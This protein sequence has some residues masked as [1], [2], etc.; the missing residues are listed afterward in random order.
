[1]NNS[2]EES[3]GQGSISEDGNQQ[4]IKAVNQELEATGTATIHAGTYQ[5]NIRGFG[6]ASIRGWIS[7]LTEYQAMK[8]FDPVNGMGLSI[9]RVRVSPNSADFAAEK[10]TIDR[11]K[12]YGASVIA[13]AWTAPADMKTNNNIVGGKL[14]PES[15]A[16]YAT[17]LRN[18]TNTVGGVMAVSPWNEPDWQVNYESMN[19]TAQE[20]GNFIANHGHNCG[21]PVM[22]PE[23]LGMNQS[24]TTTVNNI[25]GARLTYICGHI[26]GS[27]PYVL[28][29]GK[30][31]W[32]TEHITDTNDA[33]I[34]SGAMNTAR[35]IHN[36]MNAGWNMWVWW[37]IRRSY[38]LI[39]EDNNLT[40][41][42][43]VATHFSKFIRPGY[44]KIECTANP[45]S[46]VY[47]TAYRR[48][49]SI[50][51]VAINENTSVTYQPFTMNGVSVTGFDR[52]RTTSSSN[53]QQDSF[54]VSDGS[55]GINLPAQSI[56]TLVSR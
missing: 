9:L 22:A 20:I 13:T 38:G 33:N 6:G 53:L 52:W 7:D 17:H 45:T 41:R 36:V 26:Y 47:T 40:K 3:G 32:M 12:S 34:W 48:G 51:I 44:N 19:D 54:S 43:Y 56:T 2:T 55:F 27:S 14:K 42:G 50:V 31:V 10:T 21:A 29:L 30:E 18:F 37:Y 46:G 8:A 49:S 28:N 25:A 1:M 15:Y 39:D 23:T 5:Q 16:A 4:Q 24:F 35:E 11:A